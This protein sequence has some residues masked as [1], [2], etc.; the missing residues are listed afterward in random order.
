MVFALAAG[1]L[2]ALGNV[3]YLRAL[4]GL[5]VAT[6]TLIFFT[7]PLF[8]VGLGV[9]LFRTRLASPPSG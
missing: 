8:V 1:A 4:D 6:T 3:A 2:V 9:C 5:S 7:Y